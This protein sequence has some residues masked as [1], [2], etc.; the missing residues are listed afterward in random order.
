[1]DLFCIV[2]VRSPCVGP[3]SLSAYALRKL[4]KKQATAWRPIQGRLQLLKKLVEVRG[5][6]NCR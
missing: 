3:S 5:P 4:P 6:H 2:S 1:M